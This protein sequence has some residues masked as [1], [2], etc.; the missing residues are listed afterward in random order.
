MWRA[1]WR[2]CR[3]QRSPLDVGHPRTVTLQLCLL[4]RLP[5]KLQRPWHIGRASL[6]L[7]L[8][9]LSLLLSLLLFL[10]LSSW[11]LLLLLWLSLSSWLLLSSLLLV[12]VGRCCSGCLLDWIMS[13]S[14]LSAIRCFGTRRECKVK[15]RRFDEYITEKT[16][17]PWEE[18]APQ[19]RIERS[20]QGWLCSKRQNRFLPCNRPCSECGLEQWRPSV[21]ADSSSLSVL[22]T[23]GL[24]KLTAAKFTCILCDTSIEQTSIKGINFGYFPLKNEDGK[25]THIVETQLLDR[26]NE[27]TFHSSG[28]CSDQC[29]FRCLP[30]VW[31]GADILPPILL[32]WFRAA[33][34]DYALAT[35]Q[36]QRRMGAE[37]Q[38]AA[39]TG[40]PGDPADKQRL[41][42]L[43]TDCNLKV[44]GDIRSKFVMATACGDSVFSSD[45]HVERFFRAIAMVTSRK[46]KKADH[47]CG[48]TDIRSARGLASTATGTRTRGLEALVC[49]HLLYHGCI[50]FKTAHETFATGLYG[51]VFIGGPKKLCRLWKDNGC[52]FKGYAE[53]TLRNMLES[54]DV[55]ELLGEEDMKLCRAVLDALETD[56]LKV[57]VNGFH[58]KTHNE[59]CR[60]N[61]AALAVK[62][63][64]VLDGEWCERAFTALSAYGVSL[65][66][67][68]AHTRRDKLSL[69]ILH[70]NNVR[71]EVQPAY[72]EQQTT[73]TTKRLQEAELREEQLKQQARAGC[74]L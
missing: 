34:L 52:S 22:T 8:L 73:T 63:T 32:R 14:L 4:H 72:L 43:A 41:Q 40:V 49:S 36:L 44:Y 71:V 53:R 21:Q 6:L 55:N 61:N 24:F 11:L 33:K 2:H 27:H 62:G 60:E 38:C 1:G 29:Q 64:G 12:V 39:C 19:E 42:D 17:L 48:D 26:G 16:R 46:G 13:P 5:I 18:L 69:M 57:L 7:L 3:S 23:N 67:S 20:Q 70:R 28:G 59:T 25:W 50:D 10:W 37:G 51:L 58:H 15:I 45:E 54:E 66:R 47:N 68:H 35:H 31:G 56:E 65:R 30:S 74:T 9:L